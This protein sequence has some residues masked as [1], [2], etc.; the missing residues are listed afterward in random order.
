V[1]HKHRNVFNAEETET[2]V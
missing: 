2:V 1:T